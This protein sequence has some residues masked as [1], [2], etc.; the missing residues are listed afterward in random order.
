MIDLDDFK[1]YNDT[2]GHDTGDAVLKAVVGA[3][4]DCIRG[5]DTLIRYGGD[6]FLLIMPGVENEDNFNRKLKEIKRK[7]RRTDVSGYSGIHLS[8]SIGGIIADK[9]PLQNAVIRADKL[10][11]TAKSHKNTVV[12]DKDGQE[13]A[14]GDKL[15]ILIVDDSELNR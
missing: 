6:E 14:V 1:I 13:D 5:T 10:M 3:I 4:K 11:Y 15:N 12:T 8:V 2:Q 7:V 9:E